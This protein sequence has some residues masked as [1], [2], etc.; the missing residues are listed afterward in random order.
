MS[1]VYLG[2][3]NESRKIIESY[4]G[5]SKS[6]RDSFGRDLDFETRSFGDAQVLDNTYSREEVNGL[7]RNHMELLKACMEKEAH[8][9]AIASAQLIRAVVLEADK[10]RV[11]ITVDAAQVLSNLGGQS[12][13]EKAE[14]RMFNSK[15]RLAP[16]SGI[17]TGNETAKQL[18]QAHEEIRGLNDKLRKAQEQFAAAMADRSNLYQETSRVQQ[19]MSEAERQAQL[20]AERAAGMAQMT[21]QEANALKNELASLRDEL[22]RLNR[23]MTERLSK[24]TQFQNLQQMMRQKND[25]LKAMRSELMR[26]DPSAAARL[27]GVEN[28]EPDEDEDD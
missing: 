19:Q 11:Q 10:N 14:S 1:D 27:A 22:A 28:D 12:E 23:E 18:I 13:L 5:W 6:Q 8:S 17:D 16:L 3:S 20:E 9:R 25:Q 4:L 26:Y 21:Q 15:G 2:L 24:S 7:L